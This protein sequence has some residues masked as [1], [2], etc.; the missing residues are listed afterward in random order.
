MLNISFNFLHYYCAALFSHS[1]V[2]HRSLIILTFEALD[3]KGQKSKKKRQKLKKQQ[4][5][6]SEKIHF[7]GRVL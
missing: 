5:H 3:Y 7:E 1:H 4:H 6:L 2:L